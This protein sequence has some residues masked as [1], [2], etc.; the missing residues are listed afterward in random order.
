MILIS[1]GSYLYDTYGNKAYAKVS[2]LKSC[3]SRINELKNCV[4]SSVNKSYNNYKIPETHKARKVWSAVSNPIDSLKSLGSGISFLAKAL[5]PWGGEERQVLF[6]IWTSSSLEIV[7]NLAEK[8]AKENARAFGK[9]TSQVIVAVCAEK[10]VSKLG[11]VI[12][13]SAKTGKLSSVGKAWIKTKEKADDF[14]AKTVSSLDDTVIK[15][16]KALENIDEL[17]KNADTTFDYQALAKTISE[18]YANTLKPAKLIE[19]L[20]ESGQKVSM[21]K[22][23][24]VMKDSSGKLMWLEQ[25]NNKSA[26]LWHIL[27]GHAKN[28]ID[29]GISVKDIPEFIVDAV[30]SG[31]IVNE[32]SEKGAK[33]YKVVYG[34]GEEGLFRVAFGSNGF[35]V[36]AFPVR[37]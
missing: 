15:A 33:V 13:E 30:K 18:S 2:I 4:E 34:N 10:G 32:L 11:D 8:E 35:I 14:V 5:T 29:K 12:K 36:N 28:F 26:G 19:E 6:D 21:D 9:F 16:N 27:Q 23:I 37:K 25:G 17:I 31:E 20:A 22:V 7:N 24:A 1:N 3:D